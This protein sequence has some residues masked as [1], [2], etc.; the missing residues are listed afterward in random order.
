MEKKEEKGGKG[1][2]WEKEE[3]GGPR[4]FQQQAYLAREE[5]NKM[6]RGREGGKETGRAEEGRGKKA[7][8]WYK[9]VN[10]LALIL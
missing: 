4:Y 9:R 10:T 3:R 1:V 7:S 6:H 2:T 8:R 5:L